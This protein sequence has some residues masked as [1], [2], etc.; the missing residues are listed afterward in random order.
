MSKNNQEIEPSQIKERSLKNMSF[1]ELEEFMD[2]PDDDLTEEMIQ[3]IL[4]EIDE[5]MYL[6]EFREEEMTPS[7][8]SSYRCVSESME[9]ALIK[10][11]IIKV[12]RTELKSS[13]M[14]FTKLLALNPTSMLISFPRYS[15]SSDLGVYSVNEQIL[16]LSVEYDQGN[17]EVTL[18]IVHRN[19][20]GE[21]AYDYVIQI[22][23]MTTSSNKPALL[24]KT[25]LSESV[26]SSSFSNKTLQYELSGKSSNDRPYI[27]KFEE[28]NAPDIPLSKIFL[29]ENK[30]KEI[31]R[32]IYSVENY[33]K[34]KINLRYLLNGNPGT[35]KTQ[36]IRSVISALKGKATLIISQGSNFPMRD[37]FKFCKFFSPVVLIIDDVD[38]VAGSR[39]SQYD[40]GQLGTFL[41]YLDGFLPE[42]LFILGA[43]NDKL[44]IDEAASRP[45]RFDM[46]LD[47]TEI[48]QENYIDLIRRETK[49]KDILRLFTPEIL[50]KMTSRKVTGAFIVSLVKQLTSRKK[51]NGSLSYDEF[52][53]FFE[54]QHRGFYS[55][56]DEPQLGFV[57]F[58]R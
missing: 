11:Y 56:N 39:G 18:S 15:K 5:D 14:K 41:Q 13:A 8:S 52:T 3:E 46:I 27:E 58:G 22:S 4:D 33:S 6:D 24:Y 53:D 38:F 55:K 42:S 20:C 34:D 31:E 51:M 9:D 16:L 1:D 28:Y 19:N 36:I 10:D 45:G 37:M 26:S 21:N 7:N 32:F 44:L 43:T 47:V 54:L 29:P 35:G 49:D 40:R 17:Y 23:G 30:K 25:L 50:S 12:W 48:Q 57:G 2:E